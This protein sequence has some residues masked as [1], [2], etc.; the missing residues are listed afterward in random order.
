MTH[1]GANSR[2]S[3]YTCT[4]HPASAGGTGPGG[5]L[6][7]PVHPQTWE[8]TS[9]QDSPH[10][11]WVSPL[12]VILGHT[13]CS[14][15]HGCPPSHPGPLPTPHTPSLC[16]LT[17]RLPR[18]HPR[19]PAP[20][21]NLSTVKEQEK[22]LILPFGL[23]RHWCPGQRG[24]TGTQKHASTSLHVPAAHAAFAP[25]SLEQ[26]AQNR[27]VRL[28]LVGFLAEPLQPLGSPWAGGGPHLS[29]REG[30]ATR[31]TTRSGVAHRGEAWGQQSNPSSARN[32]IPRK[33]GRQGSG[34]LPKV[35]A[36]TCWA[37]DVPESTGTGHEARA[38]HT[39]L[40][41]GP[42]LICALSVNPSIPSARPSQ[43]LS[44]STELLNRGMGG[45]SGP[46]G[47]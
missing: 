20:R 7:T 43:A 25:T 31:E 47:L 10:R 19:C 37:D 11:A 17:S 4:T 2:W 40:L 9:L 22:T 30:L 27:R 16:T 42:L 26:A 21:V 23:E 13:L 33:A 32:R 35:N 44:L 39:C 45:V 34:S 38:P 1:Q 46:P 41:T 14:I 12:R 8:M 28:L 6:G 29:S 36:G 3:P 24:V 18:S 5:S 15:R